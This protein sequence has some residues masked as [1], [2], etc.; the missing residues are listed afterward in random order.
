[1]SQ[2]INLFQP[3]F[4]RQR[5]LF[6]AL[7]IAQA[8]AIFIAGLVIIYAYGRWQVSSLGDEIAALEIRRVAT[9]TQ[10]QTLAEQAA[11][12][13]RSQLVADQLREAERE[14]VQKERLLRAFR[15]RRLGNTR[16]FAAHFE[17]LARQRIDGLWLT[18]VE[19]RDGGITLVGETEAG[20]LVPRYLARLGTEA[21]FRGTEF[22]RF[23]LTRGDE[24]GSHVAFDVA[25]SLEEPAE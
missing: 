4:R 5:K 1:M 23:K 12:T 22:A 10:L 21:A 24:R 14:T 6:S 25:T 2:Q 17:A 20:E 8:T 15:T 18:R 16:G 3:V 11:A 7:T 19:V 13:P 9:M